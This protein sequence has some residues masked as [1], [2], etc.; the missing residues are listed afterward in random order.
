MV[1]LPLSVKTTDSES[2]QIEEEEQQQHC[3]FL[4]KKKNTLFITLEHFA[5]RVS[6]TKVHGLEVE[7]KED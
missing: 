2:R 7:E 5:H 3:S 1:L 6:E 4:T